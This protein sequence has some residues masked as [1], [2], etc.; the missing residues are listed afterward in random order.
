MLI[1][2]LKRKPLSKD[3]NH[4]I[5]ELKNILKDC[6]D[7]IF[8]EI[9][10][11]GPIKPQRMMILY[12]DGLVDS[13]NINEAIIKPLNNYSPPNKKPRILKDYP[14]E[15]IK[16]IINVNEI[17][18]I[19][20]FGDILQQ[21]FSGNTVLF[22]H[23][24]KEALNLDTKGWASRSIQEPSVENVTRGPR[25]GFTESIREN[26]AMIRRKIK[27]PALKIKEMNV[28]TRS[29]TFLF[30]IYMD[31]IVNQVLLTRVI[32]KLQEIQIDS[33]F[34]SGY[35]EEFLEKYTYSPFPQ[36]QLTERPDKACA[37]LMEG[38]IIILLDGVPQALILPINFF[39][40]FQSPEDY[41]ER[42]IFGNLTR[43]IRHIGF[44]IAISLPAIYVALISFHHEMVPVRMIVDL[45]QN[46]V[47]VPFPPVIEALLMELTIELLREASGRLP[48]TI[49]QTIG[50]VGAIVTGEAAIRANM[51]SPTMVIVV[52]IT[53]IASYV[54]PH[55]STTFP[56][57]LLRFPMIIMASLFG[58]FGITITWTWIII[59]MCGL[60]SFGY[61]Y[62]S[63]LA[64]LDSDL[65]NDA[66]IR[67]PLWKLW[68]R[69]K[70][71]RKNNVRW[72]KEK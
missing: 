37:N 50:I 15:D 54:L 2:D 61:P 13:K 45:A 62:L 55:Y 28:G 38:K 25:E 42:V 30:V 71:A 53:A 40:L 27:D 57:R 63:P 11:D 9:I 70:T 46:R 4:N 58:A 39:Q 21:I 10:M 32:K 65:L 51:A 7:V 17:E 19:D 29:N 16:R 35:I 14:I 12:T 66:A 68:K 18:E 8:R 36:M 72:K 43:L 26:T 34:S 67:R 22:L 47:K 69:P 24:S 41:D 1:D 6:T 60:D 3:I 23:G 48:S 44:I 5:T 59:H 56:I 49:G 52:A 31:D 20:N 64:P 33:V